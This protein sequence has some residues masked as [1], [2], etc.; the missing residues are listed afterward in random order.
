[1]FSAFS[2]HISS[3]LLC[4]RICGAKIIILLYLDGVKISCSSLSQ[5]STCSIKTSKT[6][7]YDVM[8]ASP[9]SVINIW[10]P[11]C[12]WSSGNFRIL[13]VEIEVWGW[14]WIW[15]MFCLKFHKITL[16]IFNFNIDFWNFTK[17]ILSP[18]HF[19]FWWL[20]SSIVTCVCD[21]KKHWRTQE[22]LSSPNHICLFFAELISG[23]QL[24]FYTHAPT[25]K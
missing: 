21:Q 12:A 24:T 7:L 9:G 18:S 13:V 1:M 10:E 19:N 6:C 22:A 23:A 16:S 17:I 2:V 25:W 8:S 20:I 3:M 14:S 11:I 5:A 4:L 15:K